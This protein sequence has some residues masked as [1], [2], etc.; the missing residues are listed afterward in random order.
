MSL[1]FNKIDILAKE[2]D[3]VHD[4]IAKTCPNECIMA[5]YKVNNPRLIQAWEER[6]EY[7]T[8][9]RGRKPTEM[10]L[11]HGG[12]FESCVN[13][14]QRGFLKEYNKVSAYGKGTYF[15]N[16]HSM[17]RGYAIQKNRAG[18]GSS[19]HMSDHYDSSNT[20]YDCVMISN[21]LIGAMGTAGNNQE[22]DTD[23]IDCSVNNTNSPTIFCIPYDDAALPLYFVQFH[24]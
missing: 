13:I 15:S 20:T 21:V 4:M 9:I 6:K 3:F 12:S 10:Y 18:A 23:R 24:R 7:L 16:Q 5:I 2:A 17:S 1:L 22:V 11:F 14:A 19:R 8:N